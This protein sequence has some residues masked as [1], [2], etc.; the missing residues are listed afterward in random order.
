M[1]GQT[2]DIKAAAELLADIRHGQMVL[3]DR[4]YDAEWLRAMVAD[5]GGWANIPLKRNRRDPVCFSAWL[6][7]QHN[8]IERFFNNLRN[9]R[10]IAT[11]YD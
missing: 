10:R 2:H 1:P 11:R 9:Y 3:A 8:L 7:R 5:G 4:A 6:Y